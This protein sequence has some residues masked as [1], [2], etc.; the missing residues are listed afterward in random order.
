M[1]SGGSSRIHRAMLQYEARARV[2]PPRSR[3]HVSQQPYLGARARTV[4]VPPRAGASAGWPIFVHDKGPEPRR[5]PA[6]SFLSLVP[7]DGPNPQVPLVVHHP[8]A[9]LVLAQLPQLLDLLSFST[10]SARSSGASSLRSSRWFW[11]I[12]PSSRLEA[13]LARN[14]PR[15]RVNRGT[16]IR[17]VRRRSAPQAAPGIRKRKRPEPDKDPGPLLLPYR[18]LRRT[19]V[20]GES[21]LKPESSATRSGG[22]GRS[23][24]HPRWPRSRHRRRPGTRPRAP[25]H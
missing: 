18:P 6:R 9:H 24:R 15:T 4:I 2:G 10:S 3:F 11:S 17:A 23:P 19:A 1:F 22:L 12:L 16:K 8:D 21:L 13:R 20:S 14:L 7:L 5:T 25:R